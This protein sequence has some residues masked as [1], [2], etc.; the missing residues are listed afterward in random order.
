MDPITREEKLM[1]GEQLEPITRKEYFL[2]KAAGMDVETPE[3]ITREEM[4][5]S[6]ISGGGTGGSIL[7]ENG[8]LLNSVLPYGYPCMDITEIV[9]EQSIE[10]INI[11][12][13]YH[14]DLSYGVIEIGKSYTVKFN[15]VEYNCVAWSNNLYGGIPF[16]GNAMFF[17]IEGVGESVPFA[18]GCAPDFGFDL[19]PQ[20]AGIWTVS[21]T[22]RTFHKISQDYLPDSKTLNL[23]ACYRDMEDDGKAA[24]TPAL[25]PGNILNLGGTTYDDY[26]SAIDLLNAENVIVFEGQTEVGVH[27]NVNYHSDGYVYLAF[28]SEHDNAIRI[29]YSKEYEP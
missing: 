1:A 25:T 6:M 9:P 27:A 23:Y 21:I 17:G 24:I 22:M 20:A 13:P 11:G 16:L 5:L 29:M 3:P 12:Q 28:Y 10:V 15:E 18:I 4:F 8:K 19:F 7:D 26:V 14:I 2:A